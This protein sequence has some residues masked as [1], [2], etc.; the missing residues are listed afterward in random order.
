MKRAFGEPPKTGTASTAEAGVL[1]GGGGG[2]GGG[3]TLSLAGGTT[4]GAGFAWSGTW[5]SRGDRKEGVSLGEDSG[6]ELR[7]ASSEL[8]SEQEDSQA[9]W[10][11]V[12]GSA[13][14]AAGS[15]VQGLLSGDWDSAGEEEEE[16]GWARR[17]PAV[18]GPSRLRR[19]ALQLQTPRQNG[20]TQRLWVRQ[21]AGW[22]A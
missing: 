16:E 12:R 18:L 5:R 2:G 15:P 9:R 17:W 11:V 4:G 8:D 14:A 19:H 13:A 20:Q 1:A 7:E 10:E 6:P 21:S 3:S 22:S